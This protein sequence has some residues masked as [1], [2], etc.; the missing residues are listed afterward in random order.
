[1]SQLVSQGVEHNRVILALPTE[2]VTKPK[3]KSLLR[4]LYQT[5]L[6][7]TKI[8]WTLAGGGQ[9]VSPLRAIF[10]REDVDNDEDSEELCAVRIFLIHCGVE[11]VKVSHT[12]IGTIKR[13]TPVSNIFGTK[14][15]SAKCRKFPRKLASQRRET[16]LH[17]LSYIV[18]RKEY[19]NIKGV[20]L[21]PLDDGTFEVFD[22]NCQSVFVESKEHPKLLL[23]PGFKGR[24]ISPDLPSGI[25]SHFKAALKSMIF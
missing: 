7:A 3:W 16:K 6:I 17:L 5:H 15:V 8:L 4:T 12:L 19:D 22:V 20:Q 1:M 24:F 13:Y 21:L 10:L 2:D 14:N 9:W 23:M 18:S 25:V 11:L